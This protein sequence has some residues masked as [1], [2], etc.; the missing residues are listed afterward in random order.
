MKKLRYALLMLA[1]AAPAALV[2]Q[3]GGGMGHHMPSVDDQLANMSKKLNLTDAQKPQVKAI[4]QDQ[5]DQ[6]KQ[7]MEN[8]SAS[9]DDTRAKMR[10]IHEASNT[11]IRALLTDDQKA[12]FDKMQEERMKRMQ[13]HRGG[14]QNAP[15]ANPP[16]Q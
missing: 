10:E 12:A 6:M 8:S 15:P 7:Q 5:Q 13:D 14:D 11:K 9:R 2:A 16:N 4:L 3:G 1:L